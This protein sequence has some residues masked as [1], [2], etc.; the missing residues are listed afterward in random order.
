MQPS[1]F[2]RWVDFSFHSRY[3]AIRIKCFQ[4]CFNE[5]CVITLNLLLLFIIQTDLSKSSKHCFFSSFQS[6]VLPY[7]TP[8]R[9]SNL[10]L[11]FVFLVRVAC[12]YLMGLFEIISSNQRRQNKF[13]WM[14]RIKPGATGWEVIMLPLCYAAPHPPCVRSL[15][16]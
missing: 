1:K 4:L 8:L 2:F 15:Y 11:K 14:S 9:E 3:Q 5:C 10:S 12:Y 16:H 13:L 7:I 6:S